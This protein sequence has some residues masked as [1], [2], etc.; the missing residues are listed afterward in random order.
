MDTR[1]G[2]I[3]NLQERINNCLMRS[4]NGRAMP[5]DSPEMKA[6]TAYI[7]WLSTYVPK[8]TRTLEQEFRRFS[9]SAEQLILHR[10]GLY[11]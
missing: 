11:I 5:E 1:S 10:E 3:I 2:K 8:G 7:K 4:M 9:F 6:L